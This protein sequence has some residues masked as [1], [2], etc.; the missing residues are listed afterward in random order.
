MGF[1]NTTVRWTKNE[2][3]ILNKNKDKTIEELLDL[4]PGR[5]KDSIKSK[6]KR[7][8]KAEETSIPPKLIPTMFKYYLEGE[9]EGQI[10]Q[11]MMKAGYN[12][13]LRDIGIALKKAREQSE[14]IYAEEHK[15]RPTLDQLKAFIEER[16]K[17][18]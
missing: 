3:E 15:R 10:M 6:L 7:I 8:Y 16:A 13:T 2:T 14:A 17:N 11:R 18:G 1:E 9:A 4:L 5:S 12:Y